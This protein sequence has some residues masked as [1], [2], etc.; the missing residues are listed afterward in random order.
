LWAEVLTGLELDRDG[1]VHRLE[2]SAWQQRRQ[3]L[4]ELG[5][6]LLP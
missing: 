5:G 4:Q 6:P 2:A 1:L 3:R